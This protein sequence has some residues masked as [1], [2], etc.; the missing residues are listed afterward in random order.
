MFKSD[1][2]CFCRSK[3]APKSKF[4]QVR[5][6][7]VGVKRYKI[8]IKKAVNAGKR[9]KKKAKKRISETNI[10]EPGN[11]KKIKRLS[12]LIKKS[13]GQAK[14]I[15][16]TSVTSL[17]LKRLPTASTSKKELVESRAWLMSIQ[18]LAS[19]RGE[20]PLMTQKVSQCI[21]TTV[22]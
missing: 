13:F 20:C 5:K 19:I 16:L 9:S 17:D 21:S 11:P 4:V 15:P 22:E 7:K 12:K 3:E 10:I 2:N 6:K 1:G 18:K 8:T 14:L